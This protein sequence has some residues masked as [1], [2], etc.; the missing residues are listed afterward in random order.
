MPTYV[1]LIKWTEQ[2]IKNA[3]TTVDRAQQAQA[4]VERAGGRLTIL[5]TQGTYDLIG[6]A[7]MPDDETAMAYLLANGMQ[8]NLR[9]ETMRAYTA[10]EM[11]SILAKIPQ[12]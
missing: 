3:R 9:T 1:S 4:A 6:I 11:R 7:E 5:W 2:G 10:D 8:G 12:G